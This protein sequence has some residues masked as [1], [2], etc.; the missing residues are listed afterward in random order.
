LP[1]EPHP[2]DLAQL[3]FGEFLVALVRIAAWKY[4][5]KEPETPLGKKVERVLV[6][7]AALE[8]SAEELAATKKRAQTQR[9]VLG[10]HSG[11]GTGAKEPTVKGVGMMTRQKSVGYF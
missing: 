1:A 5:D 3:D 6:A 10:T 2:D 11:L 4:H 8:R 7:V 9:K